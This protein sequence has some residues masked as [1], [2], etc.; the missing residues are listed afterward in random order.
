M[1]I[2]PRKTCVPDKLKEGAFPSTLFKTSESGWINSELF[3]EWFA[4]FLKSIPPSRP[5]LLVQDGHSSHVS[6]ELI[7]MARE[8]NVCLL[9]LPAHTSHILQPLDVGVFKSFKSS[10]NKACGNYMK[11]NPGRVITTDVLASMVGQAYPT[12]FTP[13][14][15]FSGFKKTG[16]Y[17][18]NPSAVDDRQLAPSTA[19]LKKA[20]PTSAAT[21]SEQPLPEDE[22]SDGQRM[23]F[24]PEKEKRFAR[25]F[26]EGYDILDDMEYVA[27]VRINHPER[28]FSVGSSSSVSAS[29]H[30]NHVSPVTNTSSNPNS[31]DHPSEN[32]VLSDILV[33][34][35]PKQKS[36]RKRKAGINQKTVCLTDDDVFDGLK[37]KDKEKKDNELKK[38]ERKKFQEEKKAKK[39]KL[40]KE[41][42]EK[43]KQKE[44][45]KQAK[46]AGEG[47]EEL[48]RML[49]GLALDGDESDDAVCPN[50]GLLYS[51]GEENLWVCCDKCFS[52]YDFKC[53]KLRSK[54]HLPDSYLRFV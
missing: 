1:M 17:P 13:V 20:T 34:P 12:A 22:S 9:C 54:R 32:D 24:S 44:L 52:W 8:N 21:L 16:I 3:V 40:K 30:A 18:F 45:A 43:K 23:L 27:W 42:E 47:P 37:A 51:A 19:L 14:N 2:Y 49:S 29:S 41:K 36:G 39:E 50:C 35:K 6:I 7:E 31:E 11:Q 10:F 15:I 5:V 4:F 53:T 38:L 26:E 33:L 28:C 25:Q 46:K 48:E